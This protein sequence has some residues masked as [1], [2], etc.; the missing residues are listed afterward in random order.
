MSPPSAR[1]VTVSVGT[2]DNDCGLP[3]HVFVFVDRVA[4]EVGIEWD[5]DARRPK[6]I[7]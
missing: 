6:D 4:G 2:C 5:V 1:S 3:Y 7:A